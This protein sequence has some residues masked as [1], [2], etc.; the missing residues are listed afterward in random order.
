MEAFAVLA[1]T[2]NHKIFL[3]FFFFLNIAPEPEV[4][5]ETFW[6]VCS[7]IP[8]YIFPQLEQIS[9]QRLVASIDAFLFLC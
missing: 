7:H 6:L 4:Q 1:G 9:S 3:F 8:S 2:Y 5:S